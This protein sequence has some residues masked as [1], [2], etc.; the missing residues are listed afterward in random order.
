[1]RAFAIGSL[2]AIS[3]VSWSGIQAQ[4][5]SSGTQQA[6]SQEQQPTPAPKPETPGV[7]P[8]GKTKTE[9][10]KAIEKKEQSQ[11][12]LG[13]VPQ[14]GVTS[15]LHAPALTPPEKLHLMIKSAF[16]PVEF[17]VVGL[18][19]GIS[20]ANDEFPGYG[21]GAQGYGKRY[22]ASLADETSSGIVSNFFWPVLLKEDPRYF[23]LGE[24]SIKHRIGY[25]LTQEIICHTDRGG[26][27]FSFSNVLGALSAGGM[28][29]AYYPA[30]DRGFGLTMSRSAIAIMY[31]SLGGLVD[32]FYPD[33]SR[34]L[35]HKHQQ[36][37]AEQ[38]TSS[39][40]R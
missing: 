1:M 9:Q 36:T 35:F 28:S 13:V 24:G 38:R 30:S 25:S 39:A 6:P 29:N 26:R 33:I 2:L 12:M 4:Q 20:Q 32:E 31:G 17:G 21:Q 23:R 22:G 8:P 11:R 18:Q 37:E 10:E 34:K 3:L 27:S 16:D 7:P 19:A 15:R 40:Q 14:F 5:S